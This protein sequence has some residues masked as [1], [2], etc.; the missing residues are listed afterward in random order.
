MT[1][2]TEAAESASKR[3]SR[4]RAQAAQVEKFATAFAERQ[5]KKAEAKSTRRLIDLEAK[6]Q[7]RLK[8]LDARIARRQQA[9]AG[10]A[11]GE[12]AAL[13]AS[14]AAQDAAESDTAPVPGEPAARTGTAANAPEPGA[15][16]RSADGTDTAPA[17]G[18]PEALAD[19]TGTAPAPGAPEAL[20][21]GTDAAS[22]PSAEES[23]A[24]AR[25]EKHIRDIEAAAQGT[26]AGVSLPEA[27]AALVLET[28]RG[29]DLDEGDTST[30][31][32]SSAEE[33]E[34]PASAPP[35]KADAPKRSLWTVNGFS[36][37][38]IAFWA[39]LFA[40]LQL[41]QW[42]IIALSRD[43]HDAISRKAS[44]LT[45]LEPEEDDFPPR[46]RLNFLWLRKKLKRRWRA[47]LLLMVGVPALVVLA[48]PFMC[49]S[50]YA[51][52]V[53]FTAWSTWWWVVFT[54]AKSSRAWEPAAGAA[55]PPWF[56]RVWTFLTTRM[57]GLRW[58]A[59]QRYGAS[60]GQRTQEVFAPISSTERHPWM[61]AGLATVRFLGSFPPMKFFVRPLIPVASAHLLVADVEA[62]KAALPPQGQAEPPAG[63]VP[64]PADVW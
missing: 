59:L 40:A 2:G 18:A 58:G 24:D 16:K 53:L 51:F 33:Q 19:G 46:V 49:A 27:I 14:E 52:Y 13:G 21:D 50:R 29:L 8:A 7:E 48:V 54:A 12:A 17:P 36:V 3:K 64:K 37:W 30:S 26:D 57:P 22:K 56:L 34:A 1:S 42:V 4:D 62:A 60:W 11:G 39:A 32:E 61:F 6:T 10:V 55:R 45:G 44:L 43:Y 15:T 41:A 47:F 38:S 9:A 25:I 31:S 23:T 63:E 28:T 20:E 5:V 35:R